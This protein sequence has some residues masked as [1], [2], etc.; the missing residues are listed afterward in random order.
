MK[1]YLGAA[2]AA[3]HGPREPE[4]LAVWVLEAGFRGLQPR[5]ASR[6]LDFAALRHAARELPFELA[7]ALDVAARTALADRPDRDLASRHSGRRAAAVAALLEAADRAAALGVDCVV[8]EPGTLPVDNR[9][10]EPVDLVRPGDGFDP[11]ALQRLRERVRDVH[12]EIVCRTLWEL[13]RARPEL[14][15]CLS[16]G[17]SS[18]ALADPLGL[19]LVL[20]DLAGR[21]VAYWHDAA[22]VACR[23]QALGEAQGAWLDAAAGRI[24]GFSLGDSAPGELHLPPGSGLVD[25]ALVA[26]YVARSARRC[27]LVVELDPAVSPAELRGCHAFLDKLGL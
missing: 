19:E 10:L 25:F 26:D 17:R 4:R 16:A 14:H 13:C 27:P 3:V 8:L 7:P 1:R 18:L 9:E 22:V 5:P 6:P 2:F 11:A 15:F 21:K 20:G 24:A 23:E 12:L